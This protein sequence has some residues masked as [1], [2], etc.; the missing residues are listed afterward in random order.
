MMTERLFPELPLLEQSWIP[1]TGTPVRLRAQ[2]H[3]YRQLLSRWPPSAGV[4]P[5]D[6]KLRRLP[7]CQSF[8]SLVPVQPEECKIEATSYSSERCMSLPITL[9]ERLLGAR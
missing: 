5:N 6:G 8:S 9:Q 7:G 3:P 4:P 1:G 2:L